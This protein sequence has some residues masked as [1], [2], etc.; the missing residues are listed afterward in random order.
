MGYY[1][2]A[3]YRTAFPYN[4]TYTC[5]STQVVTR[6]NAK[7]MFIVRYDKNSNTDRWKY[8]VM[9][10]TNAITYNPQQSAESN[11][12]RWSQN[13][14]M[15][16]SGSSNEADGKKP[17][18]P[19]NASTQPIINGWQGLGVRE[20]G[21]TQSTHCI[22]D[23]DFPVF[24]YSD[25]ESINKYITEGDDSGAVN[26]K[27]LHPP[28]LTI[29]VKYDGDQFPN[30]YIKGVVE[31]G[32]VNQ[33][34]VYTTG[35]PNTGFPQDVADINI[36]PNGCWNTF[37]YGQLGADFSKIHFWFSCHELSDTT[38][39]GD[40]SVYFTWTNGQGVSEVTSVSANG[41]VELDITEGYPTGEDTDGGDDN[42]W[43]DT[44]TQNTYSG[45]N[46]LTS[47]YKLTNAQLISLGN[48]LWSSTFK[49]GVFSLTNYPLEN[50]IALKAMPI[51]VTGTSKEV[52]I[53]NVSSGINAEEI[54]SA[55]N[56]E[57]AVGSPVFIPEYFQ[58]FI[59]YQ[60]VNLQIY[61]PYIG[62]KELDNLVCLNR[63]LRV[64]YIFDVIMGTCMACIDVKDKN[65]VWMQ[66]QCFQGNCGIDIAITSTNRASIENGYIN[67]GLDTISN[68]LSGDIGGLAKDIFNASTQDFHSQSNGAGN[69]SLM[70]KLT[71]SCFV[72]VRRPK[73]FEIASNYGH[74]FGFPLYQEK[75]LSSLDGYTECDN[76]ICNIGGMSEVEKAELKQLME[77][78]VYIVNN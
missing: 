15:A 5:D 21:F 25:S 40:D 14:N 68:I 75:T 8:A 74:E 26:Y 52:K 7:G 22:F 58:N 18:F 29:F 39:G 37:T 51:G 67:A 4:S 28:K 34:R 56:L 54:N 73:K 64:R 12:D 1:T 60:C 49:D 76:F 77:S 61:L 46:K 55:D 48:F 41:K 47:T 66:Y 27:D 44:N 72:I 78:G 50:V 35:Y 16:W 30:F 11:F 31:N 43:S 62:Y 23:V 20:W 45:A 10:L 69:P 38:L 33:F 9:S 32:N 24:N 71:N 59:D 17:P 2:D 36:I 70:T 19:T 57:V 13:N 42:P 6:Q 63:W 3:H 65:G 53:G